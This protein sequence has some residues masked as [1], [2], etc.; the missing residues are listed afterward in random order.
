MSFVNDDKFLKSSQ[1][2]PS[3]LA[4]ARTQKMVQN[5][6]QKSKEGQESKPTSV[7]GKAYSLEE[8]I[9]KMKNNQTAFM[10]PEKRF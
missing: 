2:E 6:T 1:K 4:L 10:K 8:Q 3:N 5:I 7:K 9:R